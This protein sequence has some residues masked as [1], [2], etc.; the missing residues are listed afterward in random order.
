MLVLKFFSVG[1]SF[2]PKIAPCDFY[3]NPLLDHSYFNLI[4]FSC[5]PQHAPHMFVFLG[6]T[7]PF[8]I[9]SCKLWIL[10][11]F[12]E[13]FSWSVL[14]VDQQ[15]MWISN[16]RLFPGLFYF[17]RCR[18]MILPLMIL[19]VCVFLYFVTLTKCCL[20]IV[21]AIS[22]ATWSFANCSQL[23]D[24]LK[25]RGGT[26]ETNMCSQKFDSGKDCRSFS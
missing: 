1:H 19:C 4:W 20:R 5:L 13:C 8:W 11:L 14:L 6:L 18:R 25:L 22:H 15:K 24:L 16:A 23:I 21:V 12:R 7:A 17:Y 26:W 3:F 10:G 9:D 2:I